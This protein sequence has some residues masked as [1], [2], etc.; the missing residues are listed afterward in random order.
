MVPEPILT[1]PLLGSEFSSCFVMAVTVFFESYLRVS[2]V[3]SILVYKD[4]D[5]KN[6]QQFAI[7]FTLLGN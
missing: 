5:L 3:V 2:S 1:G 4:S 7:V 6:P